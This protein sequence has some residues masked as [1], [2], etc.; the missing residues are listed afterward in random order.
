MLYIAESLQYLKWLGLLLQD[1]FKI[2]TWDNENVELGEVWCDIGVGG[3]G[4]EDYAVAGFD[5]RSNGGED[6]FEGFGLCDV[7]SVLCQ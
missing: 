3:V 5:G 1:W 4:F 2:A 7:V 6:A